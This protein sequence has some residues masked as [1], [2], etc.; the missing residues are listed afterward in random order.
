MADKDASGAERVARSACSTSGRRKWLRIKGNI[1]P[2]LPIE[3]E[4][5]IT[6]N[7]DELVKSWADANAAAN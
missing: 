7:Y 6:V 3:T 1:A 5:G 2:Q 4:Q